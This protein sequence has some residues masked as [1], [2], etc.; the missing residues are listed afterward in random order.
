MQVVAGLEGTGAAVLG[1]EL[2]P[3]PDKE[4][5]VHCRYGTKRQ[6]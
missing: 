5:Y 1:G 2:V 3:N 6:P 4:L